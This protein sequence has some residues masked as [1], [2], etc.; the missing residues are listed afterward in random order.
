MKEANRRRNAIDYTKG[1]STKGMGKGAVN[2]PRVVSSLGSSK[3]IN[4]PVSGPVGSPSGPAKSDFERMPY[5]KAAASARARDLRNKIMNTKQTTVN[6]AGPP[7]QTAK[8]VTPQLKAA[9]SPNLKTVTA[10]GKP[11]ASVT[12]GN[13]VNKPFPQAAAVRNAYDVKDKGPTS[14]VKA[15][16]GVGTSPPKG[17]EMI[18][19][20]AK[21]K[22][23]WGKTLSMKHP[24]PVQVATA[25]ASSQQAKEVKPAAQASV[26]AS[27]TPATSPKPSVNAGVKDASKFWSQTAGKP[28][29]DKS[30][31]VKGPGS[32]VQAQPST[33]LSTPNGSTTYNNPGFTGAKSTARPSSTLNRANPQ[34]GA[35]APKSG[36]I[37]TPSGPANVAK[38]S[39]PPLPTIKPQAPVPT[40]APAAPAPKSVARPSTSSR[41]TRQ[42]GVRRT[43][44]PKRSWG[45]HGTATGTASR[46][47]SAGSITNRAL[48]GVYE[49][50]V[51]E[52]V[53]E[54]FES[55]IRNKFLK[56]NNEKK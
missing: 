26:A 19:P 32:V 40:P 53:K 47:M 1:V 3:N 14:T 24:S 27:P 10:T 55:F 42:R 39:G 35:S 2:S 51:P 21:T 9:P 49:E 28:Q 37:G 16:T 13:Y 7:T 15:K 8:S 48:G 20:L 38:T 4:S 46:G 34:V 54:S 25:K 18:D 36:L 33:K 30:K 31:E 43:S 45:F 44:A 52:V 41:A 6:Q 5:P 23:Y 29:F 50:K 11:P 12:K 17:V 22:E 56:E